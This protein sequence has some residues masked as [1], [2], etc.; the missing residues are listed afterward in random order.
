MP[1]MAPSTDPPLPF[2]EDLVRRAG[3]L[4]ERDLSAAAIG[5]RALK[6]GAPVAVLVR[7]AGTSPPAG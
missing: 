5:Q 7:F 3:D 2:A 1:G 6:S 4:I